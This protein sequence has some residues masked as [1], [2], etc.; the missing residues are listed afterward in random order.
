M[1]GDG[2]TPTQIDMVLWETA[3]GQERL[4]LPGGKDA[5]Y[6]FALSPAGR[7]LASVSR[8]ETIHLWDAWTGEEVGQLTG[9]R[10][11]INSLSF[12][13]DGKALASGGADA[14]VLIWDVSGFV[15]A[16]KP[17]AK[18]LGREELARCWDD[19]AGTDATRAYRTMAEL[20]RRPDEAE[21]LVKDKLAAGPQVNAERAG[22]ADRGARQRRIRDAQAR[23]QGTGQPGPV[24]G[25]RAAQGPGRQ[26][27]GRGEAARYG[28]LGSAGGQGRR[29]GRA[30]TGPRDRGVGT[31]RNAGSAPA[32]GQTGEG[33]AGG[34]LNPRP[35]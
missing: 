14:T 21:G 33:A 15:P 17:V 3:T 9:H 30:P 12:A 27:L 18:K 35:V 24:G 26:A 1:A 25:S 19:L 8:T 28:P 32:A 23:E 22:P 7:L 4:R 11:W 10:G 29:P 6:Q 2:G 31:T 16:P 34:P 5:V 20:A 13:P